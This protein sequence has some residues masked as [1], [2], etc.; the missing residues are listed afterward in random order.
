MRNNIKI[1]KTSGTRIGV[2]SGIIKKFAGK[3]ADNE[4]Y[5]NYKINIIF[6]DNKYIVE[7]NKKFFNK[8]NPTDVISFKLSEEDEEVLEGEIYISSERVKEQA[9]EYN[10]RYREEL[11][12]IV[13]HGILHIA[14]YNDDTVENR[15]NMFD[16]QENYLKTLI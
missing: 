3:I 12:R 4:I 16:K 11:L 5:C 1:D 15:K 6:V 2:N 9:E 13:A 10:V 8:N 7:L 14:D